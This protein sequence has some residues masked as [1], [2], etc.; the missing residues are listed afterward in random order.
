MSTPNKPKL[1][2]K[3]SRKIYKA[4]S[5][6]LRTYRPTASNENLSKIS[7]DKYLSVANDNRLSFNT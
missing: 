3:V 1:D 4:V 2:I 6:I 7:S 5:D